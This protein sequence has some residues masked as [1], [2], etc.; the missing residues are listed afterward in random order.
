MLNNPSI[1]LL[2]D[3]LYIYMLICIFATNAGASAEKNTIL[4]RSIDLEILQ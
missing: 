3:V 2:D 4:R 1:N